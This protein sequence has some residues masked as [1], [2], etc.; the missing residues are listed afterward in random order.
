MSAPPLQSPSWWHICYS[1]RTLP[2]SR[3]ANLTVISMGCNQ[4]S[5]MPD[6]PYWGSYYTGLNFVTIQCSLDSRVLLTRP[7][8]TLRGKEE[9]KSRPPQWF[10]IAM[11]SRLLCLPSLPSPNIFQSVAHFLRRPALGIS[12]R[13]KN[14][15]VWKVYTPGR[16]ASEEVWPFN[17]C[18]ITVN[19]RVARPAP[20]HFSGGTIRI[21]A[22]KA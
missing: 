6:G 4:W 1:P 3:G 20:S 8:H 17:F 15:D 2:S 18:N 5:D 16:K 11:I 22:N 13:H 12:V 10:W 14:A 21:G 9:E 19:W 7:A